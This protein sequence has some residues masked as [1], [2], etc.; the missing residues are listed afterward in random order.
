LKRPNIADRPLPALPV[1]TDKLLPAAPISSDAS[2]VH[3]ADAETDDD[4]VV[5]IHRGK[6]RALRHPPRFEHM[7]PI[8][9]INHARLDLRDST[10]S[11]ASSISSFGHLLPRRS[12]SE[13]VKPPPIPPKVGYSEMIELCTIQSSQ[14]IQLQDTGW[15]ILK[16][17]QNK[18]PWDTVEILVIKSQYSTSILG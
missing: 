3:D 5:Q 8:S 6:T 15:D 7:A 11:W 16:I 18:N 4:E 13:V 17:Q 14:N 1:D 9:A 10:A 12:L 2:S